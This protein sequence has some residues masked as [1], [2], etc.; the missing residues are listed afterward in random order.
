M[1][2]AVVQYR[3]IGEVSQAEGERLRSS[4]RTSLSR[5]SQDLSAEITGA[6]AALLPDRGF[7]EQDI[8]DGYAAR[9]EQWRQSSYLGKLFKTVAVATPMSGSLPL[10]IF[11]DGAF[12]STP[13]PS[14]WAGLE[15]MLERRRSDNSPR[16]RFGGRAET[17]MVF[18][19]PYIELGPERRI[20]EREWLILEIDPEFLGSVL[21]PQMVKRYLGEDY[22]AELRVA[23]HRQTVL[24]RAEKPIGDKADLTIRVFDPRIDHILRRSGMFRAM[25][26]QGPGPG[27]GPGPPPGEGFG[28]PGPPPDG[29]PGFDRGRWLLS[30]RHRGGS[31]EAVVERS[32]LRNIL[33]TAGLLAVL[34]AAVA[35]LVRYTRRAQRLADLQMEFVASVSHELRTP[36]SVMRTAGHNLQGR[37]ASDPERVRTYGA[38]VEEQSGRLASI[39][40]Q[41]LSFANTNAGRVIGAREPIDVSGIIDEALEGP[42]SNVERN[43][44]SD[45]P[46]IAGDRTTLR[47]AVRNLVDNALKYGRESVSVAA[48]DQGDEIEIRIEDKGPGIPADELP[49]LFDPFYRGKKAIEDQ[50]HGT[51]LGLCLTKRIVEAHDGSIRVQSAPGKGTQFIVRLPALRPESA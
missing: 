9:Y 47:H 39:V 43:V 20:R 13:W 8:L 40:D 34:I 25:T 49:H 1:I 23:D 10:Y 11:R 41:V 17:P 19:V 46:L 30:V 15:A 27:F 4:L 51:G 5:M 6:A 24:V 50:I 3:W 42:L 31:L 12:Q 7:E 26:Q 38:L 28:G 48:A 45:L 16:G 22:E 33:V 35:A 14:E 32:R 2:L 44:S 29:G 36:L 18:E 21:L 37:V